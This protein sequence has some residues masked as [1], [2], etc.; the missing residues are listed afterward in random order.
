MNEINCP[1]CRRPL[2]PE[3]PGA[4]C[5]VCVLQGAQND[6]SPQ[7]GVPPLEEIQAAF[8][9]FEILEFIGR[10]GMGIVYKVRQPQLDRLLALK[11]LLPGL[12]QDPGFAERFAREART[13]AKLSHPNIVSVHDFGESSGFFWLTMEHIDGVNLR[14]AMQATRFTPEQALAVI[15]ELCAAL[16]FAHDQGILH[17][18]IKPENILLDEK[19]RVKVADFGIARMASEGPDDFT[20]TLTGSAL[21]STAYIAPEQIENP[22]GV[23][24]RADLYSLGVVLYE[25]LTGELP[26]GR[27]PAPSERTKS[28]PRLDQVVFKTLEKEREKRFQSADEVKAGIATACDRPTAVRNE[29][30]VG[31]PN[32]LAWTIG[33]ALC[34]GTLLGIAAASDSLLIATPGACA[35]VLGIAAGWWALWR[36]KKG[37][38]ALA[39]R[40]ILLGLLVWLPLLAGGVTLAFLVADDVPPLFG[41]QGDYIAK[42]ALL[43]IATFLSAA[44]LFH[45]SGLP[46]SR[47]RGGRRRKITVISAVLLALASLSSAKW[48]DGRWPVANYQRT[49]YLRMDSRSAW[50]QEEGA[51]LAALRKAAGPYAD[52][53]DI[54][55]GTDP[56]ND[57]PAAIVRYIAVDESQWEAHWQAIVKRLQVALPDEAFLGFHWSAMALENSSWSRQR[58][59]YSF[60]SFAIS[61]CILIAAV[62]S[63]ILAASVLFP[64]SWTPVL[65]FVVGV[66]LL[67]LTPPVAKDPLVDGPLLPMLEPEIPPADFSSPV[68]GARSLL[69]AACVGDLET[70]KRGISRRNRVLLDENNGWEIAMK[71]LGERSVVTLSSRSSA[72]ENRR[73]VSRRM[74]NSSGSLEMFLEDGDWRLDA[75]P[76]H[77]PKKP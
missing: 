29:A 37:N 15:P 54:S 42:V 66:V 41:G 9:Q 3:S 46:S 10:G 52:R 75:L 17:R 48:I 36:M 2:P 35:M 21:G 61:S 77:V 20:L 1:S 69:N 45:L 56:R 31:G 59:D 4:L 30:A 67:L 55:A 13:L 76:F 71:H 11:I 70:V 26:L 47:A 57:R 19:G 16:Q 23:D 24:H 33:L 6:A 44:A 49:I 22:S 58:E 51:V 62:L 12:E 14:Q 27:F 25:M 43:F 18:D 40:N 32:L 63:A 53:I 72:F 39:G 50:K 68:K 38:M 60:K 5:P 7:N 64:L 34:G 28:D 73:E 8:P 74:T 65:T